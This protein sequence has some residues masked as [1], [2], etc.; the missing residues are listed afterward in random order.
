MDRQSKIK[1][2][3]NNVTFDTANSVVLM[4]Y[5]TERDY[6]SWVE[7]VSNLSRIK[8]ST[9]KWND[10]V[11]YGSCNLDITGLDIFAEI[12][13]SIKDKKWLYDY[14]ADS[15]WS[16]KTPLT[17]ESIKEAVL[18]RLY[19]AR[20][21]L[22]DFVAERLKEGGFDNITDSQGWTNLWKFMKKL[23]EKYKI[24]LPLM[25]MLDLPNKD[26]RFLIRGADIGSRMIKLA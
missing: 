14:N 2:R 1:F 18:K 5:D 7:V 15:C 22:S 10:M 13:D 24:D 19:N 6:L 25:L 3:V 20:T 12:A 26:S 16:A 8:Q 17:D 21:D 4:S 23:E 9:K 11:S